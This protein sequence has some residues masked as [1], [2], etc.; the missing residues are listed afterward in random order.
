[1]AVLIKGVV[2]FSPADKAKIK[3][4]E[5]LLELN[6][7]KIVDVLDYRF[8]QNECKIKATLQSSDGTLRSVDIK[9]AEYDELGLE[10]E[11]YLMDKQHSCCN[12]CVFCFIDQLPK[13]LR[14]SLYFKDDDSRMSFLF[15]N[16]ITLTNLTEHEVERIIKL[17]ISPVNVSVHTTNP[18]LRNKIMGNRFAGRSLDIL[19]RILNA[20]I[21]V[22]CQLVLVPGMN[23]GD[24]LRRT[25]ADLTKYEAVQSIACVP[26]GLTGHREKLSR[27]DSFNQSTADSVIDITEEF[28]AK[29]KELYG[30]CRVFAADEFYLIANRT[31]PEAEYYGEFLQLENGVGM[32]AALKS[33]SEEALY[34]T[35]PP[36]SLRRV[37]VATGESAAPLV[38]DIV[39]KVS[40]KWHNFECNVVAVKNNFFGGEI[41]VTGLVT[42]T[43]IIEQLKGNIIGEELLISA[44]MLRYEG[45]MF[46]DNVTLE[47][48]E[49]A[50]NVKVRVIDNDGWSLIEAFSK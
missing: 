38:R 17:H 11:T 30:D 32:W 8:Y 18:E 29:T 1:M 21:N 24:E 45:D 47:E 5:L 9:K 14:D 39:D 26:V 4:G 13:G 22:N 7:N 27:L 46:L 12:N 42:G 16:Y 49:A 40:K 37:T 20:G 31:M 10:F 15:G 33:E 41:T 36:K 28:G 50:L 35:Q 34:D 3:S 43:D 19:W 6:G 25:L 2:P 48:V 44:S 23:D